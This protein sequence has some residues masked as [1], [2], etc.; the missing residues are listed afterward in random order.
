MRCRQRPENPQA[1]WFS[2]RIEFRFDEAAIERVRAMLTA[3]VAERSELAH[4]LP[5]RWDLAV[6]D[7]NVVFTPLMSCLRLFLA[8][9][10]KK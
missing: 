10:M 1:P 3:L 4:T 2:M 5:L 9:T 6:Y 8:R 7:S